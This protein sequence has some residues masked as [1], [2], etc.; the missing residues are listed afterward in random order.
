MATVWVPTEESSA[1]CGSRFD[2]SGIIQQV[3]F[4]GHSFF[5]FD[6][7]ISFLGSAE[8]FSTVYPPG[9]SKA[10]I[11]EGFHK[12]GAGFFRKSEEKY[13]FHR[14]YERIHAAKWLVSHGYDWV[15]FNNNETGW[16]YT[17]RLEGGG[18]ELTI[19]RTLEN[20][21]SEDILTD[22]YGHN[23]MQVDG[24]RSG[25]DVQVEFDAS[26]RLNES[27]SRTLDLIDF[28]GR[29]L[30]LNDSLSV[31]Q[32]LMLYFQCLDVSQQV[33]VAN[34]QTGACVSVES[35]LSVSEWR[36]FATSQCLCP[37]PFVQLRVPPGE[38]IAWQTR[39]RFSV[40]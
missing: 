4:C 27:R 31:D 8:E 21:G 11:G 3:D 33:R 18:R 24:A 19:F 5:T 29:S 32:S 2:R 39:Y 20:L 16:N 34:K 26:L 37:E 14:P 7:S 25:P 40:S 6:P 13:S 35:S 15:E 30:S 12:I 23:F 28:D 1:A 10:E 9:F 36:V 22:H 38:S 17:K